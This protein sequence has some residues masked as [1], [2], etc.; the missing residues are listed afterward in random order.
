MIE[1]ARFG[2]SFGDLCSRFTNA[3]G[4]DDCIAMA[5]ALIARWF[6]DGI[7]VGVIAN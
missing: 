3:I 1:Q 4:A 2:H 7:A 5:G 6:A